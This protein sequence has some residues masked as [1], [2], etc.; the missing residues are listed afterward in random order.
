MTLYRPAGQLNSLRAIRTVSEIPSDLIAKVTACDLSETSFEIFKKNLEIN[1]IAYG[2]KIDYVLSDTNKHLASVEF[3]FKYHVIDLDPYGS[4]VPFLFEAIKAVHHEGLLCVTCTDTRVLCGDDRHKCYYLYGSA[5]GGN[6]TIE[7]TGI[8]ILLYTVS[9]VASIQSKSIKVLLSVH[10]DFYIRVFVQVFESRK[11][12]WKT[13]EK[14]GLEFFCK[15]CAV[16][17]SHCFGHLNSKERCSVN[18]FELN[19]SQCPECSSKFLVSILIRR[20][21]LD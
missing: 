16:A 13:I 21:S 18:E 7:E 8:R 3:P 10:S 9:R 17:Y 6:A 12:C 5:H 2:H 14:H 20:S 1:G 15:K 19:N 11:E 4:A